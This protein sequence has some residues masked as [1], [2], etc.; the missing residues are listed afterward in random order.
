MLDPD[1]LQLLA[2]EG[3]VR[4]RDG[5]QFTTLSCEQG[6]VLRT[7]PGS[8]GRSPKGYVG[9]TYGGRATSG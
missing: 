5:D 1:D 8:R 4:M 3:M 6:S 2:K 9:V 7:L